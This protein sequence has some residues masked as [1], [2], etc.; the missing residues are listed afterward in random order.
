MDDLENR[1]KTKF[2]SYI[3]NS[4]V[5]GLWQRR[6]RR[7]LLLIVESIDSLLRPMK[8]MRLDQTR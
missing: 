4:V 1:N 3:I 6:V 8:N 5:Y 7:K 2:M